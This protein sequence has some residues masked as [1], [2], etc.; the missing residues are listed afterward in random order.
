MLA[1]TVAIMHIGNPVHL[2][3]PGRLDQL[4][5]ELSDAAAELNSLRSA[6]RGRAAELQWHGSGAR[7]FQSVLH[8]L[9]A[10][11][12]ASGSRLAELAAAVRLHRQR[13][14]SRVAAVAAAARSGH[15]LQVVERMVR[16]P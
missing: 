9:L 13:A 8:E 14:A 11:L 12:S 5:R 7:A 16:W 1:G 6:L 10:Q 15:P 3:D 2:F 4:S